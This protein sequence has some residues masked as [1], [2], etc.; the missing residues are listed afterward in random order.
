MNI[1]NLLGI[2]I[3]ESRE[4]LQ[5]LNDKL[6]ELEE[7]PEDTDV[8]NEIFRVAHTFKGMAKTMGYN[9]T[10]DLTHNMEN[11]LELL[12]SKQKKANE[13][14]VNLLF[15]CLDKLEKLLGT[16]VETGKEQKVDDVE[17]LVKGL[18]K[19]AQ[20]N[21]EVVEFEGEEV[22]NVEFNQYELVVIKEAIEKGYKPKEITVSIENEC[23]LPG[24]RCYMV[25]SLLEE[26]GE[27][28]KLIP[29]TDELENNKFLTFGEKKFLV[30][31]YLITNSE[32]E[33][34]KGKILAI[35]EIE[36]V[37]IKELAEALVSQG[38]INFDRT[39]K[40]AEGSDSAHAQ[41]TAPVAVASKPETVKK[42]VPEIVPAED[43]RASNKQ[44][45]S[46]LSGHTIRV[47]ANR[48]DK[49]VNLVGELVINKTRIF[50]LSK[51]INDADLL[52][53]TASMENITGDIQEIVMKLRM[54]PIDQVFSRFPRLVRDLSRELN[55]EINLVIIGKEIEIDRTIVDEVADPLVHLIRNSLDHGFESSEDRVK[56]GKK[57][58]GTLQLV[59]LNECD[60]IVIKIIDDGNGI[61]IDKV[62]KK[63]VEKGFIKSEDV[64]KM[65]SSDIIDILFKPGFSTAEAAT[66]LSGRGVGMDVVKTKISALNGT[67]SI[68]TEKGL[69]TTVTI[70]LPSTM[71]IIQSMLIK[72]GPETYALPLNYINEVVDIPESQIK[73]VQNRE[74]VYFRDHVIPI[75]RLEKLLKVPGYKQDENGM[76]TLILINAHEKL[77]GITVSQVIT[78]QEVVIKA[79]SKSLCTKDF[80]SGATTL[81]NGQVAL[82]LN[83]NALIK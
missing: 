59:A 1:D 70:S 13:R 5:I 39:S 42:V 73:F 61:D 15:G 68:K 46:N 20:I 11:L 16:I 76:L 21:E 50:Q 8:L 18:Q 43:M 74:V 60:N 23:V 30:K 67:V 7:N 2:F 37:D 14:I 40:F 22:E 28:F 66:N 9:D 44:T 3:D 71:A 54:V 35:S 78:Q 51:E 38:T 62:A 80:I 45:P 31:F 33:L 32:S 72:V 19:E 77:V 56:A 36:H 53:T 41:P 79:I 12:R 17:E 65:T 6:L 25:N 83:V 47:N 75:K 24:A 48:L 26:E 63:A 49:L 69:G 58:K 29:L 64:A 81:G 10:S 55:K 57:V 52:L 4:N 82:I 34:L 27:V